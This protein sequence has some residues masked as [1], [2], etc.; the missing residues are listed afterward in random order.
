VVPPDPPPGGPTQTLLD[1]G[2][3]INLKNASGLTKSMPKTKDGAYGAA[4]ANVTTIPLPGLPPVTQGG[5]LFL[6]PGA[7]ATDNGPGGADIGP[8]NVSLSNP[9]AVVWSN[10][11]QITTVNRAQGVTVTWTGGE[12]DTYVSI[13]GSATVSQGTG[14]GAVSITGTFVCIEKATAGQFTVP[15]FVTLS[16]PAVSSSITGGSLGILNVATSRFQ[17]VSIPN[18]DLSMFIT[19]SLAG[20]NVGFN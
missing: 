1:A 7:I 8:F 17:Y 9:K 18:V 14:A 3:A 12:P 2:P 5:P 4:L 11:D 15:P 6:E 20:K 13:T 16:L 10:A 19:T